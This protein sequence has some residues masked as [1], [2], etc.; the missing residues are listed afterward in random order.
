MQSLPEIIIV[1]LQYLPEFIILVFP[2]FTFNPFDS[3][4]YKV[5]K[6]F[7]YNNRIICISH[8]HPTRNWRESA[9][10]TMMNSRGLDTNP[11]CTPTLTSNSSLKELFTRV[12]LLARSCMA[13]TT[14]TNLSGTP[15]T[16]RAHHSTFGSTL[17]KAFPNRQMPHT[18]SCVLRDT[19][20]EA[21]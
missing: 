9:S 5:F 16:R 18:V 10:R 3:Q 19:S 1:S 13:C 14:L 7:S 2:M 12:L 17:S 4:S 15:A 6:R 20:L 8:G 21:V 11:W